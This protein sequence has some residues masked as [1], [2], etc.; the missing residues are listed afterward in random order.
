[1]QNLNIKKGQ[2]VVFSHGDY[3]DYEYC[4]SYIALRNISEEE[5][6]TLGEEVRS[7]SKPSEC[8]QTKFQVE[9]IKKGWLEPVNLQEISLGESHSGLGLR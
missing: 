1:M 4:G 2:L 3:S 7:N 8:P 9:L 5:V 6:L